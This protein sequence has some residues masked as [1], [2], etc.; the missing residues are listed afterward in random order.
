[1]T[2]DIAP[3]TGVGF[4]SIEGVP[5]VAERA[6]VAAARGR[7]DRSDSVEI[8]EQA[9]LMSRL[10]ALPEVRQEII[11]RVRRELALGTYETEDKIDGV[12]DRVI[13]DL[14]A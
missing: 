9:R 7:L 10:R 6:K 4:E 12:L 2:S 13:D 8:S 14:E 1:M 11:D 5:S 3:V